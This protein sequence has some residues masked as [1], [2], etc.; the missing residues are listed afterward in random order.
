MLLVKGP[1]VM[2][3]YVS[4]P[5]ETRQVLRD[6]WYVTGDTARIDEDGF[7]TVYYRPP[8]VAP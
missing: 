8:A 6:G 2:K 3:G 5:A 4:R 1:N 7:L